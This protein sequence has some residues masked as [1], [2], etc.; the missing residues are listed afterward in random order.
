MDRDNPYHIAKFRRRIP[1]V[2]AGK[3]HDRDASMRSQV[4]LSGDTVTMIIGTS[5]A[6]TTAYDTHRGMA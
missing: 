1:S 5:A 3:Q 2:D 4:E 6:T